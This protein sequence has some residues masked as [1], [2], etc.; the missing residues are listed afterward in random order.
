MMSYEACPCTHL[1]PPLKRIH[2]RHLIGI[3]DRSGVRETF[4]EASDTDRW[5]R[6]M[7]TDIHTGRFTFDIRIGREDK[8]GDV[9]LCD[10]RE[11]WSKCE[12]LRQDAVDGR[13]R[14]S[15]DMVESRV[16]TEPLDR[17]HVDIVLDDTEEMAVTRGI[18]AR[19]T[20]PIRPIRDPMAAIAC[21]ERLVESREC[22]TKLFD[23]GG[24]G[25]QE[26]NSKLGSGLLADTREVSDKVDKATE[27]FG[28]VIIKDK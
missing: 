22:R 15:E 14:S 8:L 21:M 9:A 27:S 20:E 5:F 16:D 12:V 28:H 23:V 7:F 18:T 25:T 11:E 19:R 6:I 17:E 1:S 10:P 26:E 13:Q 2:E 4:G 24:I 3:L